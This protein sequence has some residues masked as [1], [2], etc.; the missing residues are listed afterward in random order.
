MTDKHSDFMALALDLAREGQGRTRPNP[1]V[2]AIVVRD[3]RVVGEGYH[4]RAG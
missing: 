1:P 4:S 2:G 3:Q